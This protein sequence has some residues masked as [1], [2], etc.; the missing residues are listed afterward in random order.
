MQKEMEKPFEKHHSAKE[1]MEAS[2]YC[3]G[4]REFLESYKT[5]KCSITYEHNE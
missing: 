5:K 4:I 3:R 1:K 2:R